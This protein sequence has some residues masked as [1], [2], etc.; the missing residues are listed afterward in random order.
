LNLTKRACGS[1]GCRNITR[2][3]FCEEHQI[4]FDKKHKQLQ[5]KYDKERSVQHGKDYDSEWRKVR[6]IKLA[7]DPLCEDCLRFGITEP[8]VMVHH[9]KSIE[10]RPDLRLIMSNLESLCNNCHEVKPSTIKRRW[11]RG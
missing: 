3:K 10:E 8:A 7:Q 2:N 6:L 4:D 1:P 5:Q 11:G 9:I